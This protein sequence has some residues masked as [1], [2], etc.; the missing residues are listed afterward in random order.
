MFRRRGCPIRSVTAVIPELGPTNP[1]V[2]CE[3]KICWRRCDLEHIRRYACYRNVTSCAPRRICAGQLRLGPRSPSPSGSAFA[4]GVARQGS[5][6]WTSERRRG[7][8]P[9]SAGVSPPTAGPIRRHRR[10]PLRQPGSPNSGLRL[11]RPGRAD[12][13]ASRRRLRKLSAGCHL[14]IYYI[15]L[16]R[17]LGSARLVASATTY[18]ELLSNRR[19]GPC[20]SRSRRQRSF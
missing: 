20:A 6:N 1:S 17:I 4:P 5:R 10:L 3:E 14:T 11:L 8:A 12:D 2:L 16:R 19:H 9:L 7:S 15:I 13:L 18:R